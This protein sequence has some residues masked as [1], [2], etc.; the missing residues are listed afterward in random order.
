M[1][2]LQSSILTS[3]KRYRIRFETR[4]VRCTCSDACSVVRTGIKITDENSR[5]ISG[6]SFIRLTP[7]GTIVDFIS[8]QN[9]VL[10]YW[11]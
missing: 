8:K 10:V 5:L 6:E 2:S 1:L 4:S 11:L 3:S 9:A 7:G